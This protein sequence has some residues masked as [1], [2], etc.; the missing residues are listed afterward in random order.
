MRKMKL[1]GIDRNI[2]NSPAVTVLASKSTADLTGKR[3]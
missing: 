3:V 2:E 1:T